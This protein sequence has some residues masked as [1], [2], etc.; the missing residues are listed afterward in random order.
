M[1]EF[2][3][4]ALIQAPLVWNSPKKNRRYFEQRISESSEVDLF[5]LP[6]MFT[7]GFT[8]TPELVEENMFEETSAWLQ[9]VATE[10]TCA[11]TGSLICKEGTSYYNRLLFVDDHQNSYTYDKRHLFTLAGEQNQYT[12]GTEKLIV[13]YKGWKICPLICY[14]LRFPAFARNQEDYDVLLFVANWP[15]VRIHA[16][17]VLLQ[18]RAIENMSYV[19]GVNR[20]GTDNNNHYYSGHSQVLDELG[21]YIVKPTSNESVIIANLSKSQLEK[22]RGKFG[23]LRDRDDFKV[24]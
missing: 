23:F 5:I 22:S 19:A 13:P 3:R 17:N 24:T 1:Q 2:L 21:N 16:W 12:A 8:M 4:I 18:A 11:I 14:D 20:I 6:E 15:E 9:K 7:T 10:N